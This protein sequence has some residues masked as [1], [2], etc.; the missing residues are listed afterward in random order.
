MNFP[1]DNFLCVDFE[2][3]DYIYGEFMTAESSNFKITINLNPNKGIEYYSTNYRNFKFFG[4]VLNSVTINAN[5][6]THP[7]PFDPQSFYLE[8]DINL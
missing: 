6:Y 2:Q 7:F 8:G 3:T 1:Y 5:N 4:I